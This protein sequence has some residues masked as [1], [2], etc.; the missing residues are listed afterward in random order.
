MSKITKSLLSLILI[1]AM[2]CS[3]NPHRDIASDYHISKTAQQLVTW[4]TKANAVANRSNATIE[5][6]HYEIPMRLLQKSIDEGIDANVSDSLIFEKN[7]EKY[8]RW[9]INPEDT[10]WYLEVQAF[11]EKNHVDSKK[12]KFF[13]AYLTASRSMIIV[14]PENG[15]TFS[16]KVSTN[17]TGGSW[18]DKKQTWVDAQQVRRMNEWIGEV[19]SNMKTESLVI[20][21]EPLAFGIKDID[22][23]MILRSLNDMPRGDHYYM[24]GFSVL[25]GEEGARIAKL[26][27]AKNVAEFWDKHYNQPLANALAEFFAYTGAWYD[28][29]HSQNFLVELD[30]K[31]KPTGRI[32][33]RDL[34]DTY[35]LADF[36]N[37]TKYKYLLPLWEDGNVK[38]G[39]LQSA[40][41][42]LH[43]NKPPVWMS[44]GEYE[45]Y[46]KNFYT[47]FEKKFSEMSNI[48]A[49]E[50]AQTRMNVTPFSYVSKTYP[51][52]SATW[53]NYLKYANCLSGETKTLA[54]VDCPEFFL[55]K[56]K[57]VDCA[58]NL[59][60]ILMAQ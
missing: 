18:T 33:L 28:S 51:T 21:D 52:T 44:A 6:L 50:L 31:M 22:Q 10:K 5:I 9:I 45:S 1:M 12:H 14:N 42:L 43:G 36:A 23:G 29:P 58:G 59:G 25:H 37:N 46:G 11:L 39:R 55:K 57:K 41:G 7:G 16:L 3:S 30:P 48:P 47:A 32:V 4:E 56:Q 27:G 54:G 19:M 34:G 13:D 15:A 26:N 60:A 53:K 2:S 24:P 38:N 17:K 40:V 35:L 49:T 8:V 20:M